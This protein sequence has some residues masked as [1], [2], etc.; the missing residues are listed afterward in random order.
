MNICM[1]IRIFIRFLA[2][3]IRFCAKSTLFYRSAQANGELTR[4]EFPF[5]SA[6]FLLCESNKKVTDHSVTPLQQPDPVMISMILASVA[7]MP[8][9][10]RAE[11][12]LIV[13]ST[14]LLTR[15]SPP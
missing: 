13:C 5:F 7:R 8:S 11:I 4:D 9:L 1:Y 15:P 14:P 10:P 12:F 6:S 2:N 3:L